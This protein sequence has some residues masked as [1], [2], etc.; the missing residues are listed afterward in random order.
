MNCVQSSSFGGKRNNF[1][2]LSWESLLHENIVILREKTSSQ[3][4]MWFLI[5]VQNSG[6]TFIRQR[7]NVNQEEKEKRANDLEAIDR[8]VKESFQLRGVRVEH[9]QVVRPCPKINTSTF[10][11]PSHSLLLVLTLL[12]WPTL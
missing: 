10:L 4:G 1:D 9:H 2:E 12:C 6:S 11:A 3:L 8:V 5:Q 7:V